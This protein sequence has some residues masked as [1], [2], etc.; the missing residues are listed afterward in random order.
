MSVNTQEMQ[1]I[2]SSWKTPL[3]NAAASGRCDELNLLLEYPQI[4]VNIQTKRYNEYEGL[5][6]LD[7]T[8]L[9]LAAKNGKYN[10]N[11]SFL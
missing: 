8:P 4:N 1:S 2:I 6:S 7:N 3:H 5:I 11:S 10:N 9:H